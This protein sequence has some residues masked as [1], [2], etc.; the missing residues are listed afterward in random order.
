[1]LVKKR[2]RNTLASA[3]SWLLPN[4]LFVM[5][6]KSLNLRTDKLFV[7]EQARSSFLAHC[8]PAYFTSVHFTSPHLVVQF[9][10]VTMMVIY[11][12]KSYSLNIQHMVYIYMHGA[13]RMCIIRIFSR[14]YLSYA[15]EGQR[16]FGVLK[17]VFER[18]KSADSLLCSFQILFFF[19]ILLFF[20]SIREVLWNVI[21]A[22]DK[23]ILTWFLF[24]IFLRNLQHIWI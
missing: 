20:V 11:K 12:K 9:A 13:S 4:A 1:M 24:K 10:P 18:E 22:K 6:H 14:A 15:N 23:K 8:W 19:P 7:K 21:K 5:G 17:K 2:R 3:Y 16:G